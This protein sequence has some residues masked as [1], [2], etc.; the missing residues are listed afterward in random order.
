MRVVAG[1]HVASR[2]DVE[3]GRSERHFVVV[4]IHPTLRLIDAEGG[5]AFARSAWPNVQL[6]E[7]RRECATNSR[8]L[9]G[10]VM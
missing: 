8:M 6:V 7:G 5:R 9:N 1:G 4:P 2:Q 10:L 3:L